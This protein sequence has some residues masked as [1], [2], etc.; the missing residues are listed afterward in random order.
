VNYNGV[1]AMCVRMRASNGSPPLRLLV[2][3][4]QNYKMTSMKNLHFDCMVITDENRY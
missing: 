2:D 3:E 1:S 4:A